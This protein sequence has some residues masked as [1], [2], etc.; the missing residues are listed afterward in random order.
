[1]YCTSIGVACVRDGNKFGSKHILFFVLLSDDRNHR[2]VDTS[3]RYI[4]G[5]RAGVCVNSLPVS[6]KFFWCYLLRLPHLQ[7]L[8]GSA[9]VRFQ[10]FFSL[11]QPSFGQARLLRWAQGCP[12]GF[13]LGLVF[14]SAGMS[15][16]IKRRTVRTSGF[17]LQHFPCI[18]CIICKLCI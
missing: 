11:L 7:K 13:E 1:M 12:G 14:K 8:S 15:S 2:M 5:G 4:K 3:A 17:Y 18:I 6:S 10:A 16:P 9:A